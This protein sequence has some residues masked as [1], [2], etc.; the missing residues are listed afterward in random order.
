M[1]GGGVAFIRAAKVVKEL[2]DKFG[3]EQL[4][5]IVGAKIILEGIYAPLKQ[6]AEN[7][8]YSGAVVLDKVLAGKDDFGFNAATGEYMNLIQAGIVDPTKVTRSALQ[9]AV[10]TA[11][12]FLITEVVVADLPEKKEKAG[13]GRMP[14]EEEY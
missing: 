6:I 3:K 1:A 8:G 13:P 7:A 5:Q 14:M 11:S 12:M 4:A 9:N 2:I 10:S